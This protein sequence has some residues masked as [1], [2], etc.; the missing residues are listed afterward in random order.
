VAEQ[1]RKLR[2]NRDLF[3]RAAEPKKSLVNNLGSI[4]LA[5]ISCA[6]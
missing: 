1:H 2:R 6:S 3:G 4:D 5:R